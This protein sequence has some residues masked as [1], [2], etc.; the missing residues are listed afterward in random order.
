MDMQFKISVISF[1]T[2]LEHQFHEYQ[3]F[4]VLTEGRVFVT[5]KLAYGLELPRKGKK[6]QKMFHVLFYLYIYL[7]LALIA[8][9]CGGL[10]FCF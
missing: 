2:L 5:G 3:P 1:C 6:S 4:A 8:F 7:C 10:C 9:L